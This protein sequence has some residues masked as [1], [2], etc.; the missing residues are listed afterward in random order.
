[1]ASLFCYR[2]GF[3]QY[4]AGQSG[5]IDHDRWLTNYAEAAAYLPRAMQIGLLAPFPSQWMEEASSPGGKV[6]RWLSGL[7][8][9]CVYAV[10]SGVIVA[11]RHRQ[12]TGL[13]ALGLLGVVGILFYV[14]TSPNVGAIYRYRLP[15]MMLVWIVGLAG[16]SAS[17]WVQRPFGGAACKR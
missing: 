16:W 6:K 10:L 15:F 2:H 9:L 12:A 11:L 14:Y 7:E 4:F 17:G 1:M 5:N 8:M 3:I 13:I